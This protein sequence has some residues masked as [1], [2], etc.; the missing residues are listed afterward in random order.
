M[1]VMLRLTSHATCSPSP[2]VGE[3]SAVPSRTDGK[4]PPREGGAS[5]ANFVTP[6]RSGDAGSCSPTRGERGVC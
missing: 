6:L 3:G 4:A 1:S 5:L 2:L